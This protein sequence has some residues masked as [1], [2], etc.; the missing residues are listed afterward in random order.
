MNKNIAISTKT[1]L[2]VFGIL[3]IGYL[4]YQ[5]FDIILQLLVALIFSLAIEPGVKYLTKKKYPR[6]LSVTCLFGLVVLL[7]AGFFTIALP[8][9]IS[10]ARNLI[11]SLPA[12]LDSFVTSPELKAAL[13][14]SVSQLTVASGGVFTVTVEIFS[15]FLSIL[16]VFIFAL[17]LSLD[18]PNLKDR[19]LALFPANFKEYVEDTFK[20]IENNLSRWALGQML[21]MVVV[22]AVSYLGL[23]VMGVPYAVPLAIIAGM[24]EVVPVLGP[25][26]ATVVAAIVGFS[27]SPLMGSLIVAL[28]IA[29]QQLENNILVPR[30]MQKVIGFNPLITMVALLVGGKLFGIVGA[31]I[32]IPVS[33]MGVIIFHRIITFDS[34]T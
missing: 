3:V 18:L 20:K 5:I 11:V 23:L 22:G 8:L 2:T 19:F 10:Q 34:E 4:L 21:L 6:W 17:Y 33:L 27:I 16:S 1:I 15:N 12:F 26:I 31:V 14:T 29:I 24:L 28:F 30:V 13:N 9:V 25:I 7:I 32:S